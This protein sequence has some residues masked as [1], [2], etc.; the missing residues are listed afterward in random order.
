LTQNPK[1]AKFEFDSMTTQTH[2]FSL[3]PN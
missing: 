3:G 1:N 2:K